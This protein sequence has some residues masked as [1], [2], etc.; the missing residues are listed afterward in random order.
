M[1]GKLNSMTRKEISKESKRIIRQIE[2]LKKQHIELNRKYLL[3][4]DKDQQFKEQLETRGRG[5][6]KKTELVGRIHWVMKFKDSD[7]GQTIK[8]DRSRIVRVNCEWLDVL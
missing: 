8:I 2:K 7:T 5:K 6:Y 3:L 4:S 1:R